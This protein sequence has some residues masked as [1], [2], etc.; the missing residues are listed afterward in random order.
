MKIVVTGANGFLGSYVT[1]ELDQQGHTVLGWS[2]RTSSGFLGIDLTCRNFVEDALLAACPD[3]VIHLAAVSHIK[4]CR[5]NPDLTHTL[6]AAVP[7]ELARLASRHEFRLVHVSTE[8][9]FGGSPARLREEDEPRPQHM[10]GESKL[11]G[12]KEVAEGDGSAAIV[13]PSYITGEAPYGRISSTSW[14]LDQ[15]RS[16][17]RPKIITDEIRSPVSVLDVARSLADL[18]EM[19]DVGGVFHCGGSEEITRY[20]L[21]CREAEAA[22]FDPGDILPTTREELGLASERPAKLVLDSSRLA[23]VL[24][25]TSGA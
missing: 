18:V 21:A 2:H 6:N 10:Y 5:D 16:G 8:A 3:A 14:L 23:K 7:G 1:A 9:V 4:T 13:R 25:W 20:D 17:Q 11:Q 12:E 15:L 24:G 22:G 19:P